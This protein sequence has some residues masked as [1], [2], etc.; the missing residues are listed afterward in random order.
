VAS[1]APFASAPVLRLRSTEGVFGG[2]RQQARRDLFESVVGQSS[3]LTGSW[4]CSSWYKPSGSINYA[5][6]PQ[7]VALP[8][9]C[10]AAASVADGAD[11]GGAPPSAP[12]A[13][14]EECAR[15]QEQRRASQRP[16][17][18]IYDKA[19]GSAGADGYYRL[20]SG[21]GDGPD[22]LLRL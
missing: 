12:A 4:C 7:T 13:Q 9:A 22:G 21:A 11:G 10:G 17:E 18:L 15:R 5:V 1:L 8:S 19:I 2:W 3:I 14:R 6:P 20:V 16:F